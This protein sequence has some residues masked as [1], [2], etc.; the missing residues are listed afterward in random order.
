[1]QAVKRFVAWF[2]ALT[3]LL[4]FL[5]Y[6]F[7]LLSFF[8]PLRQPHDD[9]IRVACVGDSITYGCNVRGWRR[10]NYPAVLRR[11]LGDDY[12]V[13]N[14]GYSSRTAGEHGDLPYMD[15]KLYQKSLSFAPDIVI[16]MLGTNDCKTY[17]WDETDFTA[18]YTA[19]LQSYR[20][21]ESA[22]DVYVMLPP[23]V[24]ERFGKAAYHMQP[25]VLQ[26]RIVPLTASI[27]EAQQ[28]QVIDLQSAFANSA[29]LFPDGVHPDS[30]GAKQLAE[31]VYSTVF[32]SMETQEVSS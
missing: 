1:M 25:Q 27:A 12:C 4:V 8:H 20:S 21:L 7:G 17:N 2:A 24:F 26:S 28:V 23:P 29:S 13:N 22:P 31:T 14:F 30:K 10:N 3:A 18:S 32:E 5:C 9:Q 15:E 6:D 16:L 11:M 19:L